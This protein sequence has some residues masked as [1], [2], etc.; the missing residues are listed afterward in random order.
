VL[1]LH[2]DPDPGLSNFTNR[3]LPGSL[4]FAVFLDPGVIPQTQEYRMVLIEADP[5]GASPFVVGVHHTYRAPDE[6]RFLLRFSVHGFFP[7]YVTLKVQDLCRR[8][9]MTPISKG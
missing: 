7:C 3:D 5:L 2:I 8:I 1:L 9:S 4:G 6:I